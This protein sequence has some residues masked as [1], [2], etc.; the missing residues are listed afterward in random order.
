M[1]KRLSISLLLAALCAAYICP[2]GRSAGAQSSGD[3]RFVGTWA[4]TYDGAGSGKI[5][6]TITKG[7]GGKLAGKVAATTDGGD[8]TAQFKSLSFDANKMAAKY[9]FPLDEQAEIVL[10]ATFEATT[11]KGTWSLRPKGQD[12]EVAGGSWTATKK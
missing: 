2:A 3:D 10:T 9:D 7:D 11:L 12:S 6:M 1:R 5:E 4:G 8:Y